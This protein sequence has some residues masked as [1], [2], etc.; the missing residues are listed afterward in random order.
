[1][2]VSNVQLMTWIGI[3]PANRR[4]AIINDFLSDGLAGLEHMTTKEVKDMCASYAKRTDDPFP[5]ILTPIQKQ[6]MKGLVLWV[7]D[8]VRVGAAVAFPN[9]TTRDDVIDELNESIR[10]ENLR[11][12]QKKVGES[13]HDASFNN[14]L[15]SQSQWE[16]FSEELESTLAMII[17]AKGVP[18]LYVIRENDTP[19]FDPT[20]PYE[21]AVSQ[22][23]E[24][25]GE[26]YDIDAKTVHK[27]I[28]QNVNEDSDAYTYIKTLLR[29]RNGRRDIQALR[30]RYQSDA[31]KQAIINGA[32]STLETLRYKSERS[33]S[34]ERFSSKLQKAYDELEEHGREV[35]NGDI[36]DSL[37][38]RIQ[39]T[40]LLSYVTSL[41]VD[42]QRNPR[43]YKLIL[44]DIAAEV[45]SKKAVSF[46]P[47]TRG[48]SALYTR[49]GGCP[50]Q[51]VHTPNGAIFI[52]NYGNDQW[53]HDS[54]KPYWKEILEAR[55]KD[56]SNKGQNKSFNEKKR[57]SKAI[58]RN[59][60]KLKKLKIKIAAAKITSTEKDATEGEPGDGDDKAGDAFGGKSSKVKNKD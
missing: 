5:V 40:D 38:D 30:D 53:R 31:T 12:E 49:E 21:V 42:Y 47:G 11:K 34:F 37:W 35:H 2:V 19:V 1:M 43:S 59:K 36:V 17:G 32:K 13:F 14:K 25:N 16:K 48:I 4:N 60:R 9:G 44:Q 50:K 7:K 41:K 3:N 15:K 23:V 27:I 28:L 33:F 45:A 52:G 56:D 8:R 57:A 18:I 22:A 10:R 55:S 58:Q 20:L 29:H 39:T 46:A 6:R 54:V 24:L 26:E 51:G